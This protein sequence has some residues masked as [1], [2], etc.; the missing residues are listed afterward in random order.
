MELIAARF[1]Q[2]GSAKLS[3]PPPPRARPPPPPTSKTSL[4]AHHLNKHTRAARTIQS[5]Y[6]GYL[7]RKKLK[8]LLFHSHFSANS[9]VSTLDELVTWHYGWMNQFQI[10]FLLLFFLVTVFPGVFLT[11]VC[12]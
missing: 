6:R 9:I 12:V 7:I 2:K 1:V 5:A 10:L 4:F 3:P 8:Q 11:T